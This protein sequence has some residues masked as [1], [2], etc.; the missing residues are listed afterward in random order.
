MR[1]GKSAREFP[2][3]HKRHGASDRPG[4]VDQ[5]SMHTQSDEGYC[6]SARHKSQCAAKRQAQNKH[7][8]GVLRL[9]SRR[10]MQLYGVGLGYQGF[11]CREAKRQD[12]HRERINA[13]LPGVGGAG[14]DDEDQETCGADDNL[15]DQSHN[16]V[17]GQQARQD[18]Q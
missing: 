15:V 9:R 12:R 16:L 18:P 14:D 8:E 3:Q 4:Q 2:H 10:L 17:R 1:K 11:L 6:R 13:Q 7:A 5:F